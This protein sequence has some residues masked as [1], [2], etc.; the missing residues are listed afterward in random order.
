MSCAIC[1]GKKGQLHPVF[2]SRA[3]HMLLK[4][5]RIGTTMQP[6]SRH[7]GDLGR[8]AAA[9][10]LL[11]LSFNS[12]YAFPSLVRRD[13]AELNSPWGWSIPISA[14]V[15]YLLLLLLG[16]PA[17]AWRGTTCTRLLRIWNMGLCLVSGL[18]FW[19]MLLPFFQLPRHDLICMFPDRWDIP[20]TSGYWYSHMFLYSKFAELL[21]TFWLRMRKKPVSF[22]HAYHHISVLLFTWHCVTVRFWP[23]V[24]FALL[25]SFVHFI[26]YH[27]YF[28]ASFGRVGNAKLLTLLQTSQMVVGLMITVTWYLRHLL[29]SSACPMPSPWSVPFALLIYGSYLGLFMHYYV[30]RYGLTPKKR[31]L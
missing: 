21:D 23:G 7:L 29:D 2:D 10:L 1:R 5:K 18:M 27:Y 31:S 22:L 24:Y 28:L 26:M 19:G 13:I 12:Q 8:F 9:M 25:N 15:V 11:T 20:T 6:L 30:R 14:S 16:S 17:Q 4:N 3:F